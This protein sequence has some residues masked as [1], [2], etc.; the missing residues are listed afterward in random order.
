M[1]LAFSGKCIVTLNSVES[2]VALTKNTKNLHFLQKM[3]YQLG[4]FL[5]G[6]SS[7]IVFF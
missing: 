6:S 2:K 7:S 3:G 4:Q 5:G 1:K